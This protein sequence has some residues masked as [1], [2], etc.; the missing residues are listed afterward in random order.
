M[1]VKIPFITIITILFTI[2]CNEIKRTD[3]ITKELKNI[4]EQGYEITSKILIFYNTYQDSLLNKIEY[5]YNLSTILANKNA[6][7][8]LKKQN[9]NKNIWFLYHQLTYNINE[10]IDNNDK[11]KQLLKN[12]SDSVQKLG[13]QKEFVELNN[14]LN[15]YYNLNID[16]A[17]K[18]ATKQIFNIWRKD[19][20]EI[21]NNLNSILQETQKN[22]DSISVDIF[23]KEQTAKYLNLPI[24]DKKQ[25]VEIFKLNLFNE[26]QN[27]I[28]IKINKINKLREITNIYEK[29]LEH[30][31][32]YQYLFELLNKKLLE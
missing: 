4:Y 2:S 5:N 30:N 22:L 6:K 8:Q 13:Y 20:S 21:E 23:D 24:T 26:T 32:S 3:I 9:L 10:N 12:F 25:L 7:I 31:E 16:E 14:Y 27:Y 11:I 18:I 15:Q 19:V 28:T 17:F 29:V 1:K